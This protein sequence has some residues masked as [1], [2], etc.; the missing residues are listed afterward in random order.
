[1]EN[2]FFLPKFYAKLP[3]IKAPEQHPTK[4]K[5]AIIPIKI[6]N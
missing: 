5:L 3:N 6:Y 1:M 2:S 4:Y